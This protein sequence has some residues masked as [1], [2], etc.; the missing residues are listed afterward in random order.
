MIER[1]DECDPHTPPWISQSNWMSS[2][3]IHLI[4]MPLAHHRYNTP[5]IRWYI[6][7]L[8]VMCSTLA[9]SSVGGWLFKNIL[10]RFIQSYDV[11]RCGSLITIGSGLT[12]SVFSSVGLTEGLDNFSMMMSSRVG[13]LEE[14][15]YARWLASWL[16]KCGTCRTSNPSKN[17]SIL[18][19]SAR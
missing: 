16:F 4:I 13:T 6:L 15:I 3:E 2:L 12:T 11:S 18:R 9:L 5:S 8:H 19:S 10:I 1:H 7:D 17:F 14:A